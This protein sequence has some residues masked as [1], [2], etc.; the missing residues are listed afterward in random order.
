MWH[1]KKKATPTYCF[2]CK[3]N[4]CGTGW[5]MTS[6]KTSKVIHWRCMV[7]LLHDLWKRR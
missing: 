7:D 4:T 3:K 1:N 6:D 2:Y 5:V